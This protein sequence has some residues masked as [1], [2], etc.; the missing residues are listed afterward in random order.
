MSEFAGCALANEFLS[1]EGALRSM[2]AKN[3]AFL[4]PGGQKR[5]LFARLGAILFDFSLLPYWVR[6]DSSIS[7]T[8]R[9][10]R[11]KNRSFCPRLA[12]T[13]DSPRE[14]GVGDRALPLALL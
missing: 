1:S 3:R 6:E 5:R 7:S 9:S 14:V 11:V 10:V 13:N 2:L 12:K 8:L 4:S